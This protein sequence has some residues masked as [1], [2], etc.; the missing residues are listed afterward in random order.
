MVHVASCR[1]TITAT[2]I[3]RLLWNTIIK[4]HGVPK[5]ICSD[6]GSQL[7]TKAVERMNSIVSQTI[8]CLIHGPGNKRDRRILMPTMDIMVNFFD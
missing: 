5:V 4:L 6:R 3:V 2:D 1:K 7:A 8:P